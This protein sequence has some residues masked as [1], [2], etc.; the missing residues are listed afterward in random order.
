VD[1][2]KPEPGCLFYGFS[3]KG[4]QA[5]CREAYRDA[6]AL[7]AHLDNVGA[8]LQEALKIADLVRLEIHGPQAELARLRKPL[9]K[10][11]PEFFTLE[12]GFRR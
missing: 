5:H 8:I 10:L 6:A 2:T 3:F 9:A 12:F 7:L 1:Q 11:K 4:N